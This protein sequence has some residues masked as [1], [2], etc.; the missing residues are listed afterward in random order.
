MGIRFINEDTSNS[1]GV[2]GPTRVVVENELDDLN[3]DQMIQMFEYFLRASGYQVEFD[4]IVHIKE[5]D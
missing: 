4:S 1:P 3:I 5:D 2:F